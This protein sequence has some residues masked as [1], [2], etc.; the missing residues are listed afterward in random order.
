MAKKLA[1]E[2]EFHGCQTK[3]CISKFQQSI[4]FHHS[5][6]GIAQFSFVLL[7]INIYVLKE[8]SRD[9]VDI[10]L[11]GSDNNMPR[12]VTAILNIQKYQKLFIVL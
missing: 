10:V 2:E 6:G 1:G 3:C 7:Y 4:H 5:G 8:Q 11:H 12:K 9:T